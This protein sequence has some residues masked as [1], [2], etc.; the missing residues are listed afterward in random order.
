[1]RVLKGNKIE[2]WTKDT[3]TKALTGFTKVVLDLGTGDG[4]FVL[5]SAVQNP[6]VFY[7]GMDP[8]DK[9]MKIH[10]RDVQRK[11]LKNVVF[12][13]GSIELMPVE[14][15]GVFD[16]V[17]VNYPWGTLL[18]S[19]VKPVENNVVN[20]K[21]VLKDG[22]KLEVVFGYDVGLEPGEVRRLELPELSLD[23]ITDTLSKKYLDLGFSLEQGKIANK[24]SLFNT[25]WQK[26]I[27]ATS[28]S[29][30][31]ITLIKQ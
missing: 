14:F 16:E 22:G 12:V 18:E 21:N 20:V 5:K 13:V 26:R 25:N 27:E 15:E 19:F 1:M 30:F 29:F 31:K 4:T 9:Q 6:E 24:R 7:V 10:S 2:D 17:Y 28:R 8:A 11:K 3:L 23:Y